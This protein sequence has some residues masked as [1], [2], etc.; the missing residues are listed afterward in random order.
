MRTLAFTLVLSGL[1]GCETAGSGTGG[2]GG[3]GTG[4][5]GPSSSGTYVGGAG[6]SGSGASGAGASGGGGGEPGG[7][8][9]FLAQGHMGRTTL[10]CDGG[11][12]FAA[13]QSEND[14]FRCW[15]GAD[16]DC[17]HNALAGRG[18]AFGNGV[19][20][21]TFGW[22][23]PGTIQRSVNGVDWEV[24]ATDT[25][26]FADV[27][28]GNGIFVANNSPTRIS[29]DGLTWTDGGSL[30]LMIN[31]R[32]I[33]FV[34]DGDGVWIVTGESGENRDII[35]SFDG[36]TWT[37]ATTRP[38]TC[39]QYVRN[40]AYGNGV[41]ALF[42][43]AGHVCTSTDGGDTWALNPV[44][45]Y[46]TSTGVLTG[47]EF[48]V[49]AGGERFRSADGATW[50][51][52]V[53]TPGDLSLDGPVAVAPDGRFVGVHQSWDNYYEEQ[54]F[55]FSDDGLAWQTASAFV[56]SHPINFIEFG[57]VE[58]SSACLE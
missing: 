54:R 30:D 38:P 14:D 37:P 29:T 4:A 35:R 55:V 10:S 16:T 46:L 21:A 15:S 12:T 5:S 28:F 57:G 32:S 8:P 52:D 18:L 31:T 17:D 47:S 50:T 26:T 2:A 44:N 34:P 39:G 25:P 11:E 6:A 9:A 24:V 45:D 40:I 56:G 27:A 7:L 58:P 22:G 23:A 51:S 53:G 41:I 48:F 36:V 3:D 1:C 43:G 19:W 42:S 49:W 20:I 13:N 33:S